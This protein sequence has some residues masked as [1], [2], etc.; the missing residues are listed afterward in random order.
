MTPLR[1]LAATLAATS[2]CAPAIAQVTPAP[3]PIPAASG[4]VTGP[5]A[6]GVGM[7]GLVEN[8]ADITP[9]QRTQIEALRTQYQQAHQPG[10]PPDRTAMR[11]LRQQL[12]NILTTAQQQQL[13]AEIQQLR[14]QHE[15]SS[16]PASP[17]PLR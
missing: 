16:P 5:N 3:S 13:R 4:T 6:H 15:Q 14:A 17:P 2:L 12:M 7:W 9:Q 10:T 1:L 8:L 11:A